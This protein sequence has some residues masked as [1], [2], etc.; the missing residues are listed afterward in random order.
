MVGSSS[1]RGVKSSRA[2]AGMG[3]CAPRPPAMNTLKPAVRR[4]PFTSRLPD[5]ADHSHVVEH[6]LAAVRLAQPEKLILNLR[7]S[8]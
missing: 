6:R 4:P 7:G 3:R 5:D 8:R 2:R 1:S